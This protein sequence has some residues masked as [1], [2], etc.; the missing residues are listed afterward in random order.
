[1]ITH[2][3]NYVSLVLANHN[4]TSDNLLK[5]IKIMNKYN[6]NFNINDFEIKYNIIDVHYIIENY[7]LNK[8]NIIHIEDYTSHYFKIDFDFNT[9]TNLRTLIIT[10]DRY[11]TDSDIRLLNNLEILMLPKN[12]LLTDK[13]IKNLNN[14]RVLD[15]NYNRN[16]TNISI[17]N[18]TKLKYIKL[19]HNKKITDDGF[20][21]I[22]TLEYVNLGYNN[23]REL[24]LQFLIRNNFN[25]LILLK[26]KNISNE[27]KNLI[28]N[29]KRLDIPNIKY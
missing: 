25:T 26:K 3:L 14:L 5:F 4:I 23:N 12:K 16:I 10:N 27:I 9:F 18:K 21:N 1:M 20:K 15:L 24:K 8:N 29:I 17:I 2:L 7:N 13:S 19:I 11:I 28:R 6:I 22:H